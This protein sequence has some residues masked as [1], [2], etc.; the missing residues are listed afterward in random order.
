MVHAAFPRQVGFEHDAAS[1]DADGDAVL[2]DDFGEA[3]AGHVAG[4]DHSRQEVQ[5]TVGRVPVRRVEHA[6]G[7]QRIPGI[8]GHHDPQ[9]CQPI[10]DHPFT[11]EPMS[12]DVK[13]RWNTMNNP[14]TGAASTHAPA[15]TDPN[16]LATVACRL[17]M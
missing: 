10:G 5:A 14:T 11:P 16:G 13:W 15:I 1:I 12:L 6:F 8:G 9:P 3:D 7:F 4:G 17:E 2:D